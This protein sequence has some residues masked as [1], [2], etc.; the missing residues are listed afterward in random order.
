MTELSSVGVF[1]TCQQRRDSHRENSELV[2]MPHSGA[3]HTHLGQ[4]VAPEWLM[5]TESLWEQQEIRQRGQKFTPR[6]ANLWD[7]K[8]R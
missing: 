2:R 8:H 7:A 6:N 1:S 3:A 5:A 4:Q